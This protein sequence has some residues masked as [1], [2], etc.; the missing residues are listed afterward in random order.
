MKCRHAVAHTV[1]TTVLIPAAGMHLSAREPDV[2]DG[3]PF[4]RKL[5]AMLGLD[6]ASGG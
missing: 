6:V 1:L 4:N 3:Y 5:F 2:P